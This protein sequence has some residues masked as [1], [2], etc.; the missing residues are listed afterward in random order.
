MNTKT[1]AALANKAFN[2]AKSDYAEAAY[3]VKGASYRAKKTA[4]KEATRALRATKR[5]HIADYN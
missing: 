1:A 5:A 4:K 3:Y 2:A